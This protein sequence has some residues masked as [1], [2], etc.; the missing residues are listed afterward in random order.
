MN[1]T[2]SICI[3]LASDI[4]DVSRE[5]DKTFSDQVTAA[6]MRYKITYS[7]LHETLPN[8]TPDVF[9]SV[10][11][12]IFCDGQINWGRIVCVYTLIAHNS[13]KNKSE[14]G[15][16]IADKVAPWID[17]NGGWDAFI[18]NNA[19]DDVDSFWAFLKKSRLVQFVLTMTAATMWLYY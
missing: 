16:I 9:K 7:K 8:I 15:C 5:P 14:L 19:N 12:E 13:V 3:R 18:E 4:V 17:E 6:L 1:N 11:D 2:R 10:I